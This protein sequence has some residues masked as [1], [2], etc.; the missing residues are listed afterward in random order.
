MNMTQLINYTRTFKLKD[1]IVREVLEI[2]LNR[3]HP[4]YQ[5]IEYQL[6]EYYKSGV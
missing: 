2:L 6:S 5:I 4:F 3:E 1:K